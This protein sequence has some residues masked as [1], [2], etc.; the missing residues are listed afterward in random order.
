VKYFLY[1]TLR[2][3]IC[4]LGIYSIGGHSSVAHEHI[5]HD[6]RGLAIPGECVSVAM[7]EYDSVSR[8]YS[9]AHEGAVLLLPDDAV[10]L[11]PRDAP[12]D[13]NYHVCYGIDTNGA[14]V[15]YF[16]YLPSVVS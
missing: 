1:T 6:W 16:G 10:R 3:S 11:R 14:P 8:T 2:A 13:S 7:M 5:F 15:P 9:A 4:G 12:L